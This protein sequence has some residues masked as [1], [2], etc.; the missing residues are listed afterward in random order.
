MACVS[1]SHCRTGATTGTGD[2]ARAPARQHVERGPLVGQHHGISQRE[3]AH[4]GGAQENPFGA[5]GNRGEQGQRIEP[6]IDEQRVAAPDRIHVRRGF[7]RVG[8]FEQRPGRGQAHQDAAV[9]KC[10]AEIHECTRWEIAE[11]FYVAITCDWMVCDR[12]TQPTVASPRAGANNLKTS[13]NWRIKISRE[14]CFLA[15]PEAPGL[16]P[17]T[18]IGGYD[19]W[20]PCRRLQSDHRQHAAAPPS[21]PRSAIST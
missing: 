12:T 4:A 2:H 20:H 7:H 18:T 1:A 10:D 9:G 17:A 3:R 16:R 21:A 14:I 11:G 6:A 19:A 13:L 8:E 5:A 15:R